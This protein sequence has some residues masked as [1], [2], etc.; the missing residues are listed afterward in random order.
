MKRS[1]DLDEDFDKLNPWIQKSI[2]LFYET[3]Y[4][5]KIAEV[6]NYSLGTQDQIEADLRRLIR[7][8]HN[9]RNDLELLNLLGDLGKFPYDEPFW[10]LLNNVD[11]FIE[12]NPNQVHRIAEN[13]YRM[14]DEELVERIESESKLNQQT[15]PMFKNWLESNFEVCEL[16]EFK[17]SSDGIVVLGESEESWKRYLINEL[18]QNVSKRPDLVAKANNRVVI[19][20]AKWV[21]QSGGNQGGSATEVVGFCSQQRNNILRIGIIDGYPWITRNPSGSIKNDRIC[22]EIQEAPY[23]IM[24]ALLLE[25][26]LEGL[27]D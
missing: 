22:V 13:L 7:R 3:N 1:I 15:G 27:I 2:N 6:Y 8:A 18:N 24:S 16:N 17:E 26:Y 21:G 9:Q 25:D 5:D 23:N 14:T 12:K 19:G 20:E 4:L 10:Y 11:G